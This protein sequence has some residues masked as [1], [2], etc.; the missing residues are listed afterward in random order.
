MR[1]PEGHKEAV[2]A[3]ILELAA[4]ALRRDGLAGVSIPGLMKAAGL[5]HGG[6]YGYF[7]NRDE[8]VAQAVMLAAQQTAARV[9]SEAAVDKDGMLAGYLSDEHVQHP[10]F[11]CVVAALGTEAPKQSEPVRRAFAEAARGLIRAV[12]KQ[13]GSR[14]RGATLTDQA[15]RLAAQMVG[16]VVLA[17][18]V[19]DRALAQRLLAAVRKS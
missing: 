14:R 9:L 1:Y 13:L 17:R 6:F 12:D 3:N 5:T 19:D 10:E 15:L 11:G 2:R 7:E 16:A 18:L 8:L 4:R